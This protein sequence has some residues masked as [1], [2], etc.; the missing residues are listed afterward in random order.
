MMN[1]RVVIACSAVV[2]LADSVEAQSTRRVRVAAN[3][4]MLDGTGAIA[5]SI[6][7]VAAGGTGSFDVDDDLPTM[8]Q[9]DVSGTV[10][11]WRQ[12]GVGV[13]FSNMSETTG[14][15]YEGSVPA[16][17]P[18]R[19]ALPISGTIAQLAR[20]ERAT[21]AIVSW[22]APVSDRFDVMLSAGPAF[23]KLDQD[24][25]TAEAGS[26]PG[27]IP[28]L[29]IGE[30][31]FSDSATGFHLG[32]DLDYLWGARA[33]VGTTL[34]YARASIDLPDGTRSMTLGGFSVGEGC[35]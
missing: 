19:L 4:A 1:L 28:T 20:Q 7:L 12:L 5:L 18:G 13:G 22:T 21:H 17:I 11:V 14:H 8:F 10:K 29:F 6:P 16:P 30:R 33:G 3:L 32:L 23:F 24:L 35:G 26:A 9:V 27:G 15:P 34:R 25:P 2:L 31:E